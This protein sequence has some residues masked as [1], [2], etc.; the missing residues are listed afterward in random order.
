MNR[1]KRS[2]ILRPLMPGVALAV[3][4]AQSRRADA[5]PLKRS[6]V[7]LLNVGV[8]GVGEYSHLP[9]IWGPAINTVDTKSWPVRSTRMRISHVWDS[10]PEKAAEFAAKFKCEQVNEYY[11]MVGKVDGMIFGGFYEVKWW[12]KLVKPYLEAGIP[13]FINRPFS[14]SMNAARDIVD[15]ARKHNTPILCTDEREYIKEVH[16][17]R[18]KVAELVRQGTHIIGVNSDNQAGEWPAHGV[19]GLYFLLAILGMD[20]GKVALQADHWW[21][22][23]TWMMLTLQY[24]GISLEDGTR[25][26][27]PFAAVQHHLSGYKANAG[28]RIYYKGGWWDIMNH[29]TQGERMNRLYYLFFPTVMAMQRMFE[30]REM[31]WSYDYILQKTRI[32][33]AAFKSMTEHNGELYDVADLP[34]DWEAPSPRPDWIDE[35]I[36]G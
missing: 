25:Q 32:F 1:K 4:S 22:D 24:N 11:D 8:V 26:D 6:S 17:A 16:V 31:Q 30:T 28:C 23:K 13:C 3:S 20:V 10:R 5:S 27:V 33:L 12:H 9:T 21:N 34:D 35:R 19:H 2:G 7:E 15:T 29:W 18:A 36:F 14:L